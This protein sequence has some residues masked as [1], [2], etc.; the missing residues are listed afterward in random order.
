MKQK[1][2]QYRSDRRKNTQSVKNQE[3]DFSEAIGLAPRLG[4]SDQPCLSHRAGSSL[5]RGSAMWL[6]TTSAFPSLLGRA[7]SKTVLPGPLGAPVAG[8]GVLEVAGKRA[9]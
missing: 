1:S 2:H 7:G 3:A 5:G 4:R 9:G 8:S 6:E